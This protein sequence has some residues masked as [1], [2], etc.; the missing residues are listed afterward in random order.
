MRRLFVLVLA[1]CLIGLAGSALAAE[2]GQ[3]A[4]GLWINPELGLAT[5]E[6][7][8]ARYK[9]PFHTWAIPED[10]PIREDRRHAFLLFGGEW[11]EAL[12][13]WRRLAWQ[14]LKRAQPE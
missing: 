4:P 7:A 2:E 1:A 13:S 12:E 6:K 8:A 10:D 5:P 11:S 14:E 9:A 3:P